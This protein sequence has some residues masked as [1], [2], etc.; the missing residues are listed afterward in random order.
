NLVFIGGGGISNADEV[1]TLTNTWITGNSTTSAG[2]GLYTAANGG[3]NLVH[4]LVSGNSSGG[5]GGGIATGALTTTGASLNMVNSSVS[6]HP[7]PRRQRRGGACT[8]R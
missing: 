5:V 1:L 7:R 4:P 8:C 2:G 6:G 3:L